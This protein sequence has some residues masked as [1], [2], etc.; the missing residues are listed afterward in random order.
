MTEGIV[1]EFIRR[2]LGVANSFS[3][4]LD[5]LPLVYIV[6]E[7]LDVIFQN[8]ERYIPSFDVNGVGFNAV[9]NVGQILLG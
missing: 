7:S 5:L 3:L 1:V 2:A 6:N 8:K 9:D 4:V